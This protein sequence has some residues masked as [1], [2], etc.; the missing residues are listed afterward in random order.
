MGLDEKLEAAKGL[1][2]KREDIDRQLLELF[3]GNAHAKT[4]RAC[5]TCGQTGHSARKCTSF[6]SP[7]ETAV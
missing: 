2:A 3:G 7:N 4:E 6:N 5:K 1:I